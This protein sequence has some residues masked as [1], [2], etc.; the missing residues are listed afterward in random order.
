MK[1][2]LVNNHKL[3][4]YTNIINESLFFFPHF[5]D[6]TIF[7]FTRVAKENK[8][9]VPKGFG[10]LRIK[11]GRISKDKMELDSLHSRLFMCIGYEIR[12]CRM[13]SD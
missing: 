3:L 5:F 1:T 10:W 7:V 11:K 13:S 8:S 6:S 2:S 12:Y 9:I 4:C